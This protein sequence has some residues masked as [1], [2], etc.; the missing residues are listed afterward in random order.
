MLCDFAQAEAR[1]RCALKDKLRALTIRK[2]H[3]KSIV[4]LAL[5]MLR[6]IYALL[7]NYTPHPG[8]TVDHTPRGYIFGFCQT[9]DRVNKEALPQLHTKPTD[10]QLSPSS[11][12]QNIPQPFR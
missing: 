10:D 9:T 5:K 8:R 2:G 4:A 6:I 11:H 12:H 3:K 1:I 7:K